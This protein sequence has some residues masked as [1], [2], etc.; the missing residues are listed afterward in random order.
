METSDQSQSRDGALLTN[1]RRVFSDHWETAPRRPELEHHLSESISGTTRFI[2]R[3]RQRR[4][5]QRHF[6]RKSLS[7]L[8][9][10]AFYDLRF[11]DF[12]TLLFLL[13]HD[14]VSFSFIYVS[15]P[16]CDAKYI[17][18]CW[19]EEFSLNR[20]YNLKDNFTDCFGV[21]WVPHHEHL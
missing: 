13:L 15:T 4:Q 7:L 6:R 16:E 17:W 12:N 2:P 20:I 18:C 21:N 14:N 9:V 10:M 1:E 8:F 5:Q 19:S 3:E 11:Y